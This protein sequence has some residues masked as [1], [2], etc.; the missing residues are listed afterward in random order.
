MPTQNRNRARIFFSGDLPV[1][2]FRNVTL[3]TLHFP[4]CT[5]V[6]G[7]IGRP[8]GGWVG[9]MEGFEF[10][11]KSRCVI[12]SD[13]GAGWGAPFTSGW[14]MKEGKKVYICVI[15]VCA[16]R[17][18]GDVCH[19]ASVGLGYILEPALTSHPLLSTFQPI[20][21]LLN[22][23][24]ETFP[25]GCLWNVIFLSRLHPL[26]QLPPSPILGDQV[27]DSLCTAAAFQSGAP[28]NCLAPVLL[29]DQFIYA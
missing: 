10:W 7:R 21:L 2:T 29:P 13:G 24:S 25:F 1:G 3:A 26:V 18:A 9:R 4:G 8:R 20:T 5:L 17:G 6:G 23:L 28:W 12:Q 14:I 27:L 16:L 19:A 22:R 15:F 11:L